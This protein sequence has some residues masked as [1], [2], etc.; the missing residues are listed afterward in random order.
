MEKHRCIYDGVC[1]KARKAGEELIACTERGEFIDGFNKSP[2]S[3]SRLMDIPVFT[4]KP[5]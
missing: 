3:C 4:R 2:A 1:L 5:K